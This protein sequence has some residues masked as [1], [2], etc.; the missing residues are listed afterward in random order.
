ME[1]LW[2]N[3]IDF[4]VIT[5]VENERRNNMSNKRYVQFSL[6]GLTSPED[7]RIVLPAKYAEI[8][9]EG[10]PFMITV[11]QETAPDGTEQ[12]HAEI[13]WKD[14]EQHVKMEDWCTEIEFVYY[15]SNSKPMK[16]IDDLVYAKVLGKGW[17]ILMVA[18]GRV[19]TLEEAVHL[20]KPK[21]TYESSIFIISDKN[22]KCYFKDI[23]KGEEYLHEEHIT[24]IDMY[25]ERLYYVQSCNGTG[26][27]DI[28]KKEFAIKPL[29]E[30][31]SIKVLNPEVVIAKEVATKDSVLLKFYTPE[32]VKRARVI[33][34][35]FKGNEYELQVDEE[36]YRLSSLIEQ[37]VV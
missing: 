16:F 3:F 27:L 12:P 33:E 8:R 25:S 9:D 21:P 24:N 15:I 37:E 29:F 36:I 23:F 10:L 19:E 11:Q 4:Y 31:N 1:E 35:I 26:I 14:S 7:G 28:L 2:Y 20:E 22:G 32:P 30:R 17:G 18:N 13:F 6:R 5:Y 34:A